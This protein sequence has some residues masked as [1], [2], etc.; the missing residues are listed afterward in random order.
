MKTLNRNC[1]Y[2]HLCQ[3]DIDRDPIWAWNCHAKGKNKIANRPEECDRYIVWQR[4]ALA[5]EEAQRKIAI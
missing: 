1:P 5:R 2:G 3:Q 4:E